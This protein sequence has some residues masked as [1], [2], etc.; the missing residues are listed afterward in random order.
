MWSGSLAG[1]NNTNNNPP[2]NT[3]YQAVVPGTV[4]KLWISRELIKHFFSVKKAS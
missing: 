4:T 1:F 3:Q 2:G